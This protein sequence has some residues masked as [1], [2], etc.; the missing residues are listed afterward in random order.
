MRGATKAHY[1]AVGG[2]V[3]TAM[4]EVISIFAPQF[5]DHQAALAILLS[6]LLAWLSTYFAPANT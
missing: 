5:T 4:A 1:A 3:G 2:G 6:A